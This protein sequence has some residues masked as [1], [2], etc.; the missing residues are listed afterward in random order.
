M[1]PA[2]IGIF[3]SMKCDINPQPNTGG[4]GPLVGRTSRYRC[5]VMHVLAVILSITCCF[6]F[7]KIFSFGFYGL[8]EKYVL[9]K[10]IRV[11]F[12]YFN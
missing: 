6:F 3:K 7:V 12:L 11:Y 2:E 10:R 9:F 4:I 1:E 5:S 8:V